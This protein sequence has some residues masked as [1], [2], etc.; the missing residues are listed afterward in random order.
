MDAHKTERN[1]CAL[2]T[3]PLLNQENNA[4]RM[5]WKRPCM[6]LISATS[7]AGGKIGAPSEVN[8]QYGAS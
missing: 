6:V 1:A 3:S 7:T 8:T 4:Q 5:L 2:G